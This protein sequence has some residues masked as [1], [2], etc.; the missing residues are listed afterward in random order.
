MTS[1]DDSTRETEPEET[2]REDAAG[3]EP[4]AGFGGLTLTEQLMGLGAL[5]ILVVVDL[6]G[7][8]ILDE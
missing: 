5:L 3:S 2:S 1:D 6:L 7:D 8:I 4:K